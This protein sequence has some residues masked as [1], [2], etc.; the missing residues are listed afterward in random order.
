M[1]EHSNKKKVVLYFHDIHVASGGTRLILEER[2]YLQNTG[3]NTFLLTFNIQA[4]SIFNYD[5]RNIELLNA[6]NNYLSMVLSLRKRLQ[7]IRPDLVISATRS[8]SELYLATVFTSIPY[9]LH[10]NETFFWLESDLLKYALIHKRV[11]RKL[12]ASVKGHSEFI[13]VSPN[14]NFKN[15]LKLEFAA[16]ID[17]LAARRAKYVFVFSP[18]MK[19]EVRTIYGKD[20]KINV[21]AIKPFLLNYIPHV[22]LKEKLRIPQKRII[23]SISRLDYKKRVD[24]L[25]HSF[26]KLSQEFSDI[27][28]IIVGTGPEEKKLKDLVKSLKIDDRVLFTGFV[29][30]DELWDYYAACDVFAT[31]AWA[32]FDI[33]PFEALSMQK[34]VVW[35]SEMARNL[36]KDGH[37]VVAEPYVDAFAEG[38]KK[39]LENKVQTKIDLREFTWDNYFKRFAAFLEDHVLRTNAF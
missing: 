18:Q 35:S 8:S 6:G 5:S 1:T 10:F 38:I 7:E 2:D 23:L 21:G 30:D 25:I 31:P 20:A 26:S 29:N 39:A 19:W 13:P 22:D 15:R 34:N 16:I 17:Y 37:V 3:L 4:D 11:F 12:R 32:D 33:T 14:C 9:V 24:L 28:L 27:V 36:V